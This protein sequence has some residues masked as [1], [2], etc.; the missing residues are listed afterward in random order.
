MP[1]PV[2]TRADRRGQ[3]RFRPPEPS[4]GQVMWAL[5]ERVGLDL[6]SPYAYI[7]WSDHHATTSVVAFD[8][9]GIVGFTLGFC[10]PAEPDTLF[11]WQIGVDERARGEGVAGRMLDALVARNAP[12]VVEATV[13]PGNVAS[14]ALFRALGTRHGTT[15][16]QSV[17]YGED[18]FPAGHPAEI[19]LRIPISTG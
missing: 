11:V 9:H 2:T 10:L 13:T 5:A 19:R 17:A 4:D 16:T 18:L 1:T 15:V 7:M 8:D 3:T 6:N 12:A 14:T